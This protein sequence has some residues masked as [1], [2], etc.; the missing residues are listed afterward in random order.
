[1][2]VLLDIY[3]SRKWNFTI[4]NFEQIERRNTIDSNIFIL[5]NGKFG[6]IQYDENGR[7]YFDQY[8]DIDHLR[9]LRKLELAE[10]PQCITC[11]FFNT[12]CLAEHLKRRMFGDSCCSHKKL[13]NAIYNLRQPNE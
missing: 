9:T 1:M 11:E 8:E 10:F 12:K 13:I 5:P 4:S 7:E 6:S 3:R 2:L